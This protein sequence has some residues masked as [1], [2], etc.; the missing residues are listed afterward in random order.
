MLHNVTH[1]E[2]RVGLIPCIA[3][4]CLSI[5]PCLSQCS[6]CHRKMQDV[7]SL[8]ERMGVLGIYLVVYT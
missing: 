8:K 5:G 2:R 1:V 4:N 7:C 6:S 3:L